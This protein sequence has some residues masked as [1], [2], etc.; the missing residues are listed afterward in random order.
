M[1]RPRS[2]GRG[3]PRSG[4]GNDGAR[5]A[6]RGSAAPASAARL[7]PAAA[8]I[9]LALAAY[10]NTLGHQLVW[11]DP[12]SVQRWLP[13]L[14]SWWSPFLPPPDIPQWPA[15]YYR[16]LQLISY[17][18]DAALGGGAPWPFH[19]SI[20]LLHALATGL[21]F[22]TASRLLG[23]DRAAALWAA[24]LFAVHPI[25]SESVAW[26]AARPDVMVACA[27]LAALL[28]YWR[29]D[30]SPNRRAALAATLVL[31][32]LLCKEN[33]AAL[34]LLV[35]ASPFFLPPPAAATATRAAATQA[36][37]ASLAPFALAALLYLALRRAGMHQALLGSLL[38]DDPL[39]A[40]P[41]A[42]GTYLRLL[43]LPW[44]Q[45]AY[46]ADLP[47]GPAAWTG[48][49][50]ALLAGG[51]LL[52]WA[53]RRRD[54][55]A[56]FALAWIGLTL[57]PSLAVLGK[58]TT[59]PLA[60]RYLYLPSIGLCWLFGAAMAGAARL[61]ARAALASRVA[62]ALVVAVGFLL[63]VQRNRVWV[64]NY[65]LWSD[66]AARNEVD[67]LPLR[68]LAA[69][70]L[71]RGDA[72]AAERLFHQALARRNTVA[73]RRL[74]YNNLGTIALGRGD[75]GAA[76]GFYRQS[77][78]LGPTPDALYNLG[79]IALQRARDPARDAAASA[80]LNREARQHFERSL[81]ANP[82]DAECHVGLGYTLQ[83]EGDAAAARRHFEQALDLGLP[84][85]Q[86]E[87]VRRMLG[88]D[89]QPSSTT[90]EPRP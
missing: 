80:A 11:D 28:V 82:F 58:P 62:G 49:A 38:P 32:A 5:T 4:A 74:I 30:Q 45:N 29:D 36:S 20:V 70:T 89:T 42:L 81:A 46:I 79:L 12:I 33:A 90:A 8:T 43:V 56:L 6:A 17:R 44:P 24:L 26:M 35:P 27:G 40:Y 87:A 19:L 88:A 54:R 48:A 39:A 7:L 76:E 51:A 63:T 71:A 85:A 68:S 31:V 84:P 37:A 22:A 77:L 65:S 52:A 34:L 18:I 83:A 61:G 1:S 72:A 78:E 64:D 60:E 3:A 50:L 16:P 67:G 75:D 47:S 9:A 66:T 21:V 86:A 53:W 15:D 14:P 57:A 2:G 13:A 55:T 10:A 69:A 73:G 25:H 41:L 23:D 59:A